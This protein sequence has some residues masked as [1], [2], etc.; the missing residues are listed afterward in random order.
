MTLWPGCV[1]PCLSGLSDSKALYGLK[2]RHYQGA[3]K[4]GAVSLVP[5]LVAHWSL[6]LPILRADSFLPQ[7]SGCHCLQPLGFSADRWVCTGT[8]GTLKRSPC[9]RRSTSTPGTTGGRTWTGTLPYS[10]SRSPL[11]SVT[12]FTL[13]ACPT[14]RQWPGWCRGIDQVLGLAVMLWGLADVPERTQKVLLCA[15]ILDFGF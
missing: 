4:E 11:P 13:C 2:E 1:H 5:S 9:W 6:W 12:T 8:S 7:G 14:S 15:D 3:A 10:S